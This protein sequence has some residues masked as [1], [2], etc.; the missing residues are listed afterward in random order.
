MLLYLPAGHD[1]H[2]PADAPPQPL[3]YWP[4]A[5]D[6]AEQAE[7]TEAPGLSIMMSRC[8]GTRYFFSLC[9][10]GPDYW[11]RFRDNACTQCMLVSI[12]L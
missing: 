6:E 4:A 3:K 10:P 12:L 2:V 7:Q 1:V 5:H 11:L 9:P 8:S